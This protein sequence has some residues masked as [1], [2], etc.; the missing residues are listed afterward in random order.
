MR[1]LHY[2]N[3]LMPY[4]P[5]RDTEMSEQIQRYDCE[6]KGEYDHYAEMVATDDGDYVRY[7]AHLSLV[8]SLQSE[9]ERYRAALH[10]IMC[11]NQRDPDAAAQMGKIAS[12]ASSVALTPSTR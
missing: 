1:D 11:V 8:T 4:P 3:L 7:N 10:E 9:V 2:K 5:Q 6:T 12:D